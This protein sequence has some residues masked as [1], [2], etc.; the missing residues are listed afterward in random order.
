MLAPPRRAL[1]TAQEYIDTHGISKTVEETINATVKA[2]AAEPT[3][4]MVRGRWQ[5]S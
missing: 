1:T 2:K 4:F 3:S 5:L